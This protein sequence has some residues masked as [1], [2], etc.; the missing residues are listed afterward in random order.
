MIGLQEQDVVV[1]LNN[2]SFNKLITLTENFSLPEYESNL[3][4]LFPRRNPLVRD[5]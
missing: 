4:A 5:R 3:Y 2:P 1:K